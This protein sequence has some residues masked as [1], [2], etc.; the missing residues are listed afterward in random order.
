MWNIELCLNSINNKVTA[1][2]HKLQDAVINSCCIAALFV[3]PDQTLCT[4]TVFINVHISPSLFTVYGKKKG[5]ADKY[6]QTHI[7]LSFFHVSMS[8]VSFHQ[9]E[10]RA[11]NEIL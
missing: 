9:Q 3:V 1:R 2:K 10:T 6:M 11:F 4:F 8:P 5:L 7:H